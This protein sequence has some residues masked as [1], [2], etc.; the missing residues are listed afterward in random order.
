MS[1]LLEE[2]IVD[3]NALK[4]AAL[5]NAEDAILEK[6]SA[7]I[8]NA[9]D[10]LLAEAPED[11]LGLEEPS[12]PG[13][14]GEVPE[15]E[16]PDA[17]LAATDGEKLCPCPEE[18]E[19]YEVNFKELA[20]LMHQEDAVGDLGD[21]EATRIPRETGI[22]AEADN[23]DLQLDEDF[24]AALLEEL[25]FDHT[26]QKSGWS[27]RPDADLDIAADE[28]MASN[29]VEELDEDSDETD[30]DDL[31]E[32]S[33]PEASDA[34]KATQ[35]GATEESENLEEELGKILNVIETLK[36][37]K[38]TLKTQN[39][40]IKENLTS[41]ET[42][43]NEY[44]EL[45]LKMKDRLSEINVSNAKLLYTNRVLTSD[46]LNERQKNKIVEA[47]SN[48]RTVEEA[49]MIFDTLQSA[50]GTSSRAEP[51]SLSEAVSRN[52]SITLPRRRRTEARSDVA[53]ERM[54]ILAGISK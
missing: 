26:P 1:S 20:G 25:E 9:V 51:K 37:E 31:K 35:E 32:D 15:E 12:L 50:V 39:D 44:K 14:P 27:N 11:E 18:G 46:S 19:E 54:K 8:K 21:R 53:V 45:I 23:E 30:A 17:P 24:I 13:M 34:D 3:A 41:I 43:N 4:E 48:S 40:G 29:A 6:Y 33:P 10:G 2:A 49:R 22:M 7:E 38:E 52:N 42:T 28:V 5:K 16:L 36:G 47:I